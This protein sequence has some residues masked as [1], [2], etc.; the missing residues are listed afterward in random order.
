MNELQSRAKREVPIFLIGFMG[1]GKSTIG[2]TL[3]RRLNY[4]FLDSDAIIESAAGRSIPQIFADLGEDEFRRLETE[5]LKSTS[6]L[7]RVVIALGGGAYVAEENRRILRGIGISVWID[8]PL[9]LCWSRVSKETH[10]PLLKSYSEMTAL[11]QARQPAYGQAD[12]TVQT[13]A[14]PPAKVVREI[15]ELLGLG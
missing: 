15:M 13:G 4:K 9:D 12:L 10:R 14:R 2:K 11:L 8:T 7:T 3:A 1:A 6:G 5:A